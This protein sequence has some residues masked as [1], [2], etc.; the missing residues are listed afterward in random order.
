MTEVFV[1]TPPSLGD[2][3]EDDAFLRGYLR[4]KLPDDARRSI[5]PDLQ[6]LGRQSGGELY[7]LQLADRLHEP[8]LTQWDA[9]GNRIDRIDV[10]PLWQRAAEIAARSRT[11]RNLPTSARTAATRAFISSPPSICFIPPR[12]S[13]PVRSR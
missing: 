7:E 12:T 4:R 6:E 2:V 13:T 10:T 3:F 1:Q 5:E 8:E 9:W 11:D